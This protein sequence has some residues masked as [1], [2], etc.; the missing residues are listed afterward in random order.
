MTW[1]YTLSLSSFYRFSCSFIIS[2]SMVCILN[3]IALIYS[4]KL[5]FSSSAWINLLLS[6]LTLCFSSVVW[7][8]VVHS[9][10]L[11][12]H[13]PQYISG[14]ASVSIVVIADNFCFLGSV[15][16][17][18]VRLFV[19]LLILPVVISIYFLFKFLCKRRC[20]TFPRWS[21]HIGVTLF[22]KSG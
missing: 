16:R 18:F 5:S 17:Y 4:L 20:F 1:V 12:S 13:S 10:R 7:V 22:V 2:S 6:P 8:S 19:L 11:V 9:P 3:D 21:L 15:L 14:L